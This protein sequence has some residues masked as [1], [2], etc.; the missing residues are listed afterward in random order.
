MYLCINRNARPNNNQLITYYQHVNYLPRIQQYP[1]DNTYNTV[2]IARTK[3]G[4][5]E[6]SRSEK[7]V[8]QNRHDHQ[9]KQE[10]VV[11]RDEKF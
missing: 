9:P 2:L 10:G 7:K 3:A 5:M 1:V 4:W 6:A 11:M 8:L